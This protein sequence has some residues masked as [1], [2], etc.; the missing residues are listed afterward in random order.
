MHSAALDSQRTTNA[1]ALA[2]I[3]RNAS[4][5]FAIGAMLA[6]RPG[7]LKMPRPDAYMASQ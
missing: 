6:H 5:M 2:E 1:V 4:A 7:Q 3:A